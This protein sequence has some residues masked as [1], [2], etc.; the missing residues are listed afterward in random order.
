MKSFYKTVDVITK[1]SSH[2][3]SFLIIPLT[4]VICYTIIMRFFFSKSPVWG[5]EIPLFLFGIFILIS[6]AEG[7]RTNSHLAVDIFPRKLPEK[8]QQILQILSILIILFVCFT[9]CWQG[10]KMALDSTLIG[11][12]SSHQSTFNPP[13]WWFKWFIPISALLIFL[14]AFKQLLQLIGKLL[15]KERENDV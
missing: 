4:L 5:F 12:R 11:E 1:W 2:L 7:L 13:I 8:G 10:Y 14:Q 9:L 3:A 6:G 15:G